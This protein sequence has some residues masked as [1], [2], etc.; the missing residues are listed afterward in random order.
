MTDSKQA[1]AP[2]GSGCGDLIKAALLAAKPGPSEAAEATGGLVR[3]QLLEASRNGHDILEAAADAAKGIAAA[4]TKGAVTLW[5]ASR[6]ATAGATLAAHELR[7]D[8]GPV[9]A[10]VTRTLVE[11][12]LTGDADFGAAAKGSVQGAIWGADLTGGEIDP[13]AAC[14]A[15]ARVAWETAVA[16]RA[17]AGERVRHILRNPIETYETGID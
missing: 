11:E 15:A 17:S 8:A 1:E 6:G 13:A 9:V 14:R 16:K 7:R 4:A 3:D 2:A 12:L 10:V 5:L